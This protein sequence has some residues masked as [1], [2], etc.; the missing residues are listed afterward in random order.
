MRKSRMS[1]NIIN[2]CVPVSPLLLSLPTWGGGRGGGLFPSS[3]QEV[4]SLIRISHPIVIIP[5]PRPC[6]SP[7]GIKY[8]WVI[9]SLLCQIDSLP[10]MS[11]RIRVID[12]LNIQT[13]KLAMC[14]GSLYKVSLFY[15]I[16]DCFI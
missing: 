9:T 7:L 8:G 2:N 14:M 10:M 11:I 6:N 4:K 13:A 12:H 15:S 3:R 1:Y 5:Y 16:R